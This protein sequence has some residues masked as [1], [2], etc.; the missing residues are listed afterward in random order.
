MTSDKNKSP[1]DIFSSL[2]KSTTL[3]K[4]SNKVLPKED[5]VQIKDGDTDVEFGVADNSQKV[6]SLPRISS[7]KLKFDLGNKFPQNAIDTGSSVRFPPNFYSYEYSN[8]ST[9]T[10]AG[11]EIFPRSMV[12]SSATIEDSRIPQPKPF[13]QYVSSDVGGLLESSKNAL[14]DKGGDSLTPLTKRLVDFTRPINP[15]YYTGM[16]AKQGSGI[17][18]L[19]GALS[20]GTAGALAMAAKHMYNNWGIPEEYRDPEDTIGKALLR[21]ALYTGG[22]GALL[23]AILGSHPQNRTAG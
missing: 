18:A 6:N 4:T 22:A 21:G 5:T 3:G 9:G 15:L 23:G 1:F 11:Q 14:A 20:F 19:G 8:V 17:G 16:S 13:T 7:T 12:K 10:G 2:F